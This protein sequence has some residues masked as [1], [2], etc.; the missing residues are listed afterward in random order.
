MDKTSQCMN[1]FDARLTQHDFESMNLF[2]Q[3]M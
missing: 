1:I 3:W 2:V